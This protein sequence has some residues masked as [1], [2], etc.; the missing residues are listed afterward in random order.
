[1][2]VSLH[3]TPSFSS[4]ESGY[5]FGV[6]L[7]MLL[8]ISVGAM[9]IKDAD[10]MVR[11][12]NDRAIDTYKKMDQ[13]MVAITNY[14]NNNTNNLPCPAGLALN[15][16]NVNFGIA[17]ELSTAPAPYTS[18]T[19][20]GGPPAP[21]P[22][23]AASPS[24]ASVQVTID[25]AT[26][27]N[28]TNMRAGAVPVRTLSLSPDM[29]FD[30]WGNRF[31]YAIIEN[32]GYEY[33]I[34]VEDANIAN[35]TILVEDETGAV[36]P[37]SANINAVTNQS[38]VGYVILSHG[39]NGLGAYNRTGTRKAGCVVGRTLEYQNCN[40]NIVAGAD[41]YTFVLTSENIGPDVAA[42]AYFDDLV[43]WKVFK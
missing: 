26:V 10:V 16:N 23:D 43:R 14:Q 2:S 39:P 20:P 31:V 9:I 15:E 19:T 38:T 40:Y 34:W 36:H 33:D 11:N 3:R 30:E 42:A 32:F 24:G 37:I 35:R 12:K 25:G 18:C 6:I 27:P 22:A 41:A 1:M 4:S 13:I 17:E 5:G 8:L 21:A 28:A 7:A 29:A